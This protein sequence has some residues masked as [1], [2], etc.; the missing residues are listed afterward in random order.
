MGDRVE[1]LLKLKNVFDTARLS[2]MLNGCKYIS[3]AKVLLYEKN[4]KDLT[5]L[6]HYVKQ[7]VPG[8]YK[9][10]FSEKKEKLNNYAAYCGYKGKSGEYSC[11][12]EDFCKYLKSVL[13]EPSQDDVEMTR[14]Y[15]EIK[16]GVL[17]TKL[18]TK[19]NGLIPY[20]LHKYEL[21]AILENAS[22]YLSFLNDCDESG[23][24]V[25]EKIIKTFE[26]KVPYYVGPL[27]KNSSHGWAVRFV[28]KQNEKIY[29][30][31]FES[32]VDIESSASKFIENLIGRCTYTG[33]KVLPKDSL[34]YS[35][36]ALLN[37]INTLR[38]NGK[39]LPINA[40]SNLINDLFYVS[41]Q[42]ITKKRVKEYLLAN[43]Y[44]DASDEISG[45]DDKINSSLKA[46]HDF[47]NI[48]DKTHDTEMVEN[49][50]RSIL[51]FGEDKKMLKK[52]LTKNTHG[53]TEKDIS[54]ICRLK[55]S[56]WG[57]LSETFLTGIYSPNKYGEATTIMDCLRNSSCNLMQLLSD[58]YEFAKNAELHRSALL[59]NNRGL[60][61][62]LD[63]LYIAPAVRRSIR[64]TVRIVDEIVKIQK[65]A[66]SKIFIE[67]ARG[68][69][70]DLKNKRTESRKNKL[71]QLYK[72]CKE[73]SS[74]LF[75][76]LENE[77][78]NKL[79]SDKLY[80][81][82]T[83]MGK[84]MYTGEPIDLAA[85]ANGELYDIDHIFPQSKVKD[86]SLDNRVLVKNIYNREKSNTYPI[87]TDIRTKMYPIWA[88]LKK[89]G[90]ISEK[91]FDRLTRSYPLTDKELSDF[92]AR[93]LVETQQSTKALAGLLKDTLGDKT[94]IVYSKAGN[95]SDFRHEYDMIKS[96][97]V[98]DLHHAKDAYLNIVVGNVYD[99]KFT[100]RFFANIQN[101]NYSLNKVFEFPVKGAW[102]CDKSFG[103]VR[104]TMLKNNVL[105]T[106]M[107]KEVKGA[108]YD[109][110]IK[111]AGKGQLEKKKGL[112]IEKYGGYNKIS[113]AY[114]CAVEHT[115]KKKR[116]RTIEPVYIYKKELFES[117]PEKYCRNILGLSEPRII[118][119]KIR[120]DALLELDGKRIN[121]SSRTG[122]NIIYKHS[123][124]LA[125]GYEW[126]KYIK[127]LQKYA[128][129]CAARK[130]E[131]PITEHDGI[132][133]GKNE[134]LY[135]LFSDKCNT[136]VYADFFKNMRA[137]IVAN[138]EKFTEMS[139]LE[140]VQILLEILKAFKCNAQTS[141]LTKLC[142]KGVTG[143]IQKSK[144]ISGFTSAYIIN[145]SVTGLYETKTDLLK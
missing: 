55:Y 52:W 97:E 2:G 92:V 29:P 46:Y 102:D 3:E 87:S 41:K 64:Q 138:R 18:R 65:A 126:E 66:P 13:P 127:E 11:N 119:S 19:E 28:D 144:K 67:M 32:V 21:T 69:A 57:R 139:M 51:I 122:N 63:E 43:G 23:I 72:D 30:W 110:Q 84:C 136:H 105:V 74:E 53:L 26:F 16:D 108:L 47:K 121:I 12:Q 42:K 17:L 145:Q 116:I 106:R 125:V 37:E 75:A 103:I 93:Q 9:S 120:I 33:E 131:L 81:Y 68:S 91:K 113:G 107:P 140:Q 129:R 135:D 90:F 48:I 85:L 134:E 128:E 115:E 50:I 4:K 124:Q 70:Q 88:Q 59:G 31:N 111:P 35:E 132:S 123:Y 14:I 20:Q 10:I 25:K 54:Y 142:G 40:K 95:V 94:R 77:D 39:E 15:T 100:S 49:I 62:K 22:H 83:Q 137:D 101:E 5:V 38:I 7:T 45:I 143:R 27:N 141:D 96:R 58:D 76:K 80:L 112:S 99:T 86:N 98:N 79:R 89:Q 24:S 118:A 78:E 34:L 130:A 133:A 56:D 117:D 104:K 8:K 73:T 61:E 1:L 36:F 109:L 44:I 60:T 71:I 114:F 6:K 82:Y